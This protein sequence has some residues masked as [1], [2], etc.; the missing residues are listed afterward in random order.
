[1]ATTT[2]II[3]IGFLLYA[4][5]YFTYGKK[6]ERDVVKGMAPGASLGLVREHLHRRRP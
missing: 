6:L 1:M 2:V 5:L 4:V 3:I